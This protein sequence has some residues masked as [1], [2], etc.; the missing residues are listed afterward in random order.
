MTT[1][2]LAAFRVTEKNSVAYRKYQTPQA[3]GKAL[4]RIIRELKP[5]YISVRV[6]NVDT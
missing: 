2:V 5:D 4:E 3:A 1:I 6:V